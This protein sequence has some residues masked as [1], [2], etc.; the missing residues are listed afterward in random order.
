MSE[1]E[2]ASTF[3]WQL[4]LIIAF[5][6]HVWAILSAL[7]NANTVLGQEG[8]G[9]YL[10]YVSY[11]LLFAALESAF[12]FGVF[13]LMS[14]LIRPAFGQE[15]R[16]GLIVALFGIFCFWALAD[17]AFSFAGLR[18]V[19][20]VQRFAKMVA[21]SSTF[22]VVSLL[23]LIVVVILSVGGTTFAVLRSSTLASRIFRAAQK[24]MVLSMVYLV[25]DIAGFVVVIIRNFP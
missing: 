12:I 17:F 1:T 13:W 14:R 11:S 4:L 22:A 20:L 3:A 7:Y 10:G 6:I 2:R 25:V 19:V 16:R 8:P 5:P 18:E 24:V 9:Y 15:T 23:V 21:A